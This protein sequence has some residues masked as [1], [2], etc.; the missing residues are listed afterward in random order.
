MRS[1]ARGVMGKGGGLIGQTLAGIFLDFLMR[2]EASYLLN[3]K[4]HFR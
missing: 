3:F 4:V 2:V 1:A